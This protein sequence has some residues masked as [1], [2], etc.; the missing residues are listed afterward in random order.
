MSTVERLMNLP[1]VHD[2]NPG[3]HDQGVGGMDF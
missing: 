2:V 1:Q 3:A